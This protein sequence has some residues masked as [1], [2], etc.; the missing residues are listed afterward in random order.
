MF[1]ESKLIGSQVYSEAIEYWHTYLW[2]HR[3]PKTRLLHRLGSW[4]S[5][6]GIL[7]SLA[8]YGWYLFPAGILIGYGF[9]FAGHYLVEK[10]RPLTLNQPIRAG[11]CNWVMF[12]YEMFF[13]VEAKLKELKHQKLDTRK[14]SSI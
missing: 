14:M 10:N 9:A 13:D 3:H 8:G 6:L 7:L 5:L 2:H 1:A 11:I 4:I 12:F